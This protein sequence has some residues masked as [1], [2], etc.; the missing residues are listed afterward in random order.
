M[1]MTDLHELSFD[2][3]LDVLEALGHALNF[4]R[5]THLQEAY[6]A[7][8]LANPLPPDMLRNSYQILQPLFSRTNVLEMAYSQVGLGYLNGWVAQTLSDRRELR[9]RAFSSRVLHIPAAT[10]GSFRR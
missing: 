8:L 1:A 10:V 6:E 5:N 3:I 4:D 9:V 7:A 2:E